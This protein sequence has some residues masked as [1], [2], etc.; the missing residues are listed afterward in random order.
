MYMMF[1]ILTSQTLTLEGTSQKYSVVLHAY[2][3]LNMHNDESMALGQC[4]YKQH[5]VTILEHGVYGECT[6][7]GSLII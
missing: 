7:N 1:M 4:M 5:P 6:K 3:G 2:A